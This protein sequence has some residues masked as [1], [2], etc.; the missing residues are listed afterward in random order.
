MLLT[1][2]GGRVAEQPYIAASQAASVF[3]F[4]YFLV[5]IPF[6]GMVEYTGLINE[7][8]LNKEKA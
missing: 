7:L 4:M 2:L 3:Y 1:F 5:I 8:K 6:L